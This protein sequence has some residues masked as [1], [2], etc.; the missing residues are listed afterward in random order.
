MPSPYILLNGIGLIA[1][2]FILDRSLERRVPDRR[3]AAYLL[4]V[5]AVAVGWFCAHILDAIV[6]AQSFTRAGFT[7]YGGL[8]GGS[9]FFIL[10]SPPWLRRDQLWRALNCAVVPL[11]IAHG[12]GR[13][14]CFFAGCCYGYLIGDTRFRHPAQLYEAA[15][16]FLLAAILFAIQ[17]R[18]FMM[19]AWFY[20]IGYAP[21][22]FAIEFL[23]GDERGSFYGLSTSQWISLG[24]FTIAISILILRA[25]TKAPESSNTANC[26]SRYGFF[27]PETNRAGDTPRST[28]G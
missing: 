20:L 22:R 24:L 12:I 2:L 17:R 27:S 15:Y 9:L 3:D 5:S 28:V 11:V 8:L 6:T 21:F 23:R 26:S 4:F 7:Y 16:L 13:V 1:G 14:G 10:A 19:S 25:K 18:Y